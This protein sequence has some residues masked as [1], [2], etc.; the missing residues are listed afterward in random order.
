MTPGQSCESN[1]DCGQGF[2]RFPDQV[3]VSCILNSNCADNEACVAGACTKTSMCSGDA[4]CT[5][6]KKCDPMWRRCVDCAQDS[7][8]DASSVCASNTCQPITTCKNS[9]DCATGVCD[10]STARC[11]ECVSS[12]DCHSGERCAAGGCVSAPTCTSDKDCKASKQLCDTNAHQ[13]VQ[14]LDIADCP[15]LH[16]CASGLCEP[17]LCPPGKSVCVNDAIATCNPIGD[18]TDAGVACVAEEHC[19]YASG[20][21]RCGSCAKHPLDLIWAIDTNSGMAN[22]ALAYGAVIDQVHQALKAQ[23]VDIRTVLIGL[24]SSYPPSTSCALGHG[25]C[26]PPPTGSDSCPGQT[27]EFLHVSYSVNEDPLGAVLTTYSTWQPVLRAKA[28]KVFLVVGNRND[29]KIT[30]EAGFTSGIA[31]LNP[32]IENTWAVSG[33]VCAT[34]TTCDG[35]L[36]CGK[37]QTHATRCYGNVPF[38]SLVQQTGGFAVDFCTT[39]A[40]EAAVPVTA[41][42]LKSLTPTGC[43]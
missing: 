33:V 35:T 42:L 16:R 38:V 17:A 32:P 34:T 15:D 39:S 11:V 21:P 40:M 19:N 10:K 31:K 36:L 1:A 27:A 5:P 43:E 20:V 2:C 13:C 28:Q 12:S 24:A 41:E 18:G 7:D 29:P 30:T 14:C 8:C 22:E 4:D 9:L 37:D 25:L 23:G 26:V 6:G 3:C